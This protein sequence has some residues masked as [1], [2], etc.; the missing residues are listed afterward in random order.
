MQPKVGHSSGVSSVSGIFNS[1]SMGSLASNSFNA[2]A[3]MAQAQEYDKYV[4][5]GDYLKAA[6]PQLLT[7]GTNGSLA[8]YAVNNYINSYFYMVADDDVAQLGKP[9]F[10][11]KVLN[12]IP[13][14]IMTQNADIS[15]SCFQVEKDMIGQFLTSGFFYE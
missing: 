4:A 12:T 7:G 3:G 15:I 13:G 14:F 9:L 10:Q 11:K 8:A 6:A 1:N 2:G 5:T